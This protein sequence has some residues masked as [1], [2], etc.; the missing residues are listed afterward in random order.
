[1]SK[2]I[3]WPTSDHEWWWMRFK[4]KPRGKWRVMLVSVIE[5]MGEQFI[6]P[7]EDNNCYSRSI[8]EGWQARFLPAESPPQDDDWSEA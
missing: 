8:C 7:H 4:L 1:M 6:S 5:S 2:P 3:E